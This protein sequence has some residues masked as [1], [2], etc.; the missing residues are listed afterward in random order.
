MWRLKTWTVSNLTGQ[1]YDVVNPGLETSLT[2]MVIFGPRL[3]TSPPL[4]F[5]RT[6]VNILK[7]FGIMTLECALR[8]VMY[9]EPCFRWFSLAF[10]RPFVFV[11]PLGLQENPLW[12]SKRTHKNKLLINQPNVFVYIV[13]SIRFNHTC[14][15]I[16]VV[17]TL[18][19]ST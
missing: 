10:C 18:G 12:G 6:H 7:T 19:W 3:V 9:N 4:L 1:N 15:D 8:I 17:T 14:R 13:N 2:M 11:L 16:N 5:T